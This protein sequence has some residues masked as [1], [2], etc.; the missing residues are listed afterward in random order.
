MY[1]CIDGLRV[2]NYNC[3]KDLSRLFPVKHN[4][5][6]KISSAA[7]TIQGTVEY[8]ILGIKKVKRKFLRSF[9]KI[10]GDWAKNEVMFALLIH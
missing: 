10:I 2:V 9:D 7:I 5:K 3:V 4:N 6:I 8:Y 1:Y